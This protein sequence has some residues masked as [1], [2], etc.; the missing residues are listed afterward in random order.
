VNSVKVAVA[1]TTEAQQQANQAPTVASSIADATIVNESGTREVSL[2]SV[3]S[4]ADGDVV[5]VAQASSSDRDGATAAIAAVTVTANSEGTA[6]ITV[7]AEDADGSSVSETF[8]VVVVRKYA[9]LIAQVYEWRNDP[10]GVN[11][12]SH[13]DRWD[14]ALLAFGETAAAARQMAGRYQ[15]SRWNPVAEALAEIEAGGSG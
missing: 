10:N 11:D 1:D 2:S 3:F 8:E 15:A 5:T 6:N 12:K 7:T 4:D 9:A 14:R 13:T